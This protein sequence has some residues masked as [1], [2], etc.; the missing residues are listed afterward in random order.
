LKEEGQIVDAE[1]G[2]S[3]SW[4]RERSYPAGKKRNSLRIRSLSFPVL[5]SPLKFAKSKK[6]PKPNKLLS[7]S[8]GLSGNL[9]LLIFEY[10]MRL[11][12]V[13]FSDLQK[14]L[15]IQPKA[16]KHSEKLVSHGNLQITRSLYSSIV[17]AVACIT[18][19]VF[20]SLVSARA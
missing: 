14:Y 20:V 19:P 8:P 1:M 10:Q 4:E 2:R 3:P 5:T 6:F 11:Y 18:H 17:T 9:G 16:A 15:Q 12:Q 7:N 13:K